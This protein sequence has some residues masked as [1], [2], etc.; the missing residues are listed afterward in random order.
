MKKFKKSKH[1]GLALALDIR[2]PF[3][4]I[5]H[6]HIFKNLQRFGVENRH[7][8]LVQ[9][10]RCDRKIVYGKSEKMLNKGTPQGGVS[11]PLL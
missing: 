6:R 11:S 5:R 10:L 9:Q 3:D 7:F 4:N 1:F 2:G 8:N